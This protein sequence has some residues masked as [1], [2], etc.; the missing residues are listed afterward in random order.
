MDRHFDI[1]DINAEDEN[2]LTALVIALQ[3][4]NSSMVDGILKRFGEQIDLVNPPTSSSAF[5]QSLLSQ[6]S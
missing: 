5:K 1:I 4:N 2:Q 6:Q 3:E